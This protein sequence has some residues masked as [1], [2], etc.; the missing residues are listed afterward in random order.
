MSDE[1]RPAHG[2]HRRHAGEG[3]PG[4]DF[5]D[6]LLEAFARERIE[7]EHLPPTGV[8]TALPGGGTTDLDFADAF[9]EAAAMPP[10]DLPGFAAGVVRGLMRGF[11]RR[12]VPL[13]THY[14]LPADDAAGHAVLRA[15]EG[16][17]FS[18]V[19]L[20]PDTIGLK[21]PDGT[22]GKFDARGYRSAVEGR[23]PEEVEA[24]AA[25][26]ARDC[27]QEHAR[28]SE[29]ERG[30][31]PA[32]PAGGADPGSLRIRL[33][34]EETLARELTEEMRASL[35]TRPLAPGL[36]ETVAVDGPDSVQMLTR[37]ALQRTGT[38][39]EQAFRTAVDNSLGEPAEVSRHEG[40]GG[41]PLVHIG[42]DHLFMA[43]HVHAL[44]RALGGAPPSGALVA[45]PVPQVVI[46]HPIDGHHP[47]AALETVQEVAARFAEGD[48]PITG[49]VY[50]WR[51]GGGLD[52]RPDLRPV[53]VDVDHAA[54]SI[55]LYADD[56]FHQ[57][58]SAF[59]VP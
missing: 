52:G 23:L 49:Q 42:G 16:H 36:W 38:S 8:R 57:V 22:A 18:P 24:L 34:A 37:A 19:F 13:G 5:A 59:T 50:W 45:L 41:I 40:P 12:G 44:D 14:P 35:V 17:G 4:A 48:K 58:V 43:A 54:K 26:F 31:P 25:D 56:D 28:M 2:R 9:R 32:Q 39:P 1:M 30:R 21:A 10:A 47:I 29:Q 27:A 46:A 3:A 51:P 53:R 55:A 33:H 7:A 6:A 11:R 20:D 15:L